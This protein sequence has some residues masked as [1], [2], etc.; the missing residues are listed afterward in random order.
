MITKTPKTTKHTLF[1]KDFS[2]YYNGLLSP[3][4]I[5]IN[6]QDEKISYDNSA[7]TI[8]NLKVRMLSQY[9]TVL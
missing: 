2:W 3:I 7:Y 9:N 6:Y 4:P 8:R 1:C 5:S